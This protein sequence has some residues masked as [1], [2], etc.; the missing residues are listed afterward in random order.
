M[1][2]TAVRRPLGVSL[3]SILLMISGFFDLV[4]GIVLLAT[5]ND[6]GVRNALRDVSQGSITTL[7]IVTIG[8]GVAVLVVAFGLRRGANWARAL[9][10]GVA[11]ARLIILFWSVAAYHSYHWY[12][13]LLP[14]A[15]YI[16]VA[17]YLFYDED[18]K[19]YF[20]QSYVR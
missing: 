12:Q 17:G 13:A 6:A 8:L 14:T 4:A 7:A 19:R 2:T 20:E 1:T 9:V 11:I 3:L 10:A 5:R 15:I 18:A 16:L